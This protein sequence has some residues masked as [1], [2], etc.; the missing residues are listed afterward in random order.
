MWLEMRL[1][2]KFLRGNEGFKNLGSDDHVPTLA[3]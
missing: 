2:W 3:T 1:G